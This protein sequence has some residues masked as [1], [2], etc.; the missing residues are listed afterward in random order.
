MPRFALRDLFWLTLVGMGPE[1]IIGESLNITR[2]GP[3]ART[4]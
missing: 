1:A 4:N 2:H 3:V